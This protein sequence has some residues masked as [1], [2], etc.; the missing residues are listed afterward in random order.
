MFAP[1]RT[2]AS[3]LAAIA[4]A[5]L[6]TACSSSSASSSGAPATSGD[7]CGSVP[8]SFQHD[9][10]P[11]FAGSCTATTICHGQTG[12]PEAE[13]LYLGLSASGGTDGP[14]DLAAIYAGLVGAKSLENPTMDVVAAGDL[15]HSFLWHKLAGDPNSDSTV[16]SGCQAQASGPTPCSDCLPEAP[17]GVQ[18]PLGSALAPSA[19]CTLKNWIAQGALNN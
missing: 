3:V 13:N 10:V 16:T 9:V 17:C 18:M 11:I 5:C 12:D 1:S 19:T 8:V 2:A 6:A 7:G 14:G 15:Q 4:A